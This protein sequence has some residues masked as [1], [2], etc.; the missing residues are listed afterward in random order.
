[1]PTNLISVI[2]AK[3]LL[4]K[5][6]QGYLAHMIGT[7]VCYEDIH[8]TLVVAKFLDVF[9]GELLRLLPEREVKFDIELILGMDPISIAPYCMAPAELKEIKA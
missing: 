4:R 3:R 6:C 1:M 2:K 8:Q 9:P 5:G 7:R